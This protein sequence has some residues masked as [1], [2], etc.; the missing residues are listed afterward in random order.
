MSLITEYRTLEEN[1]KELQ[2]RLKNLSQDDKLKK[3][4]EF[5][6]KLRTLMG[7]YQKSLRDIIALLDPDA[8][9]GKAQRNAKAAPTG[10]KR[11][12]KVKQYKNPN[13]GE[14]IETKGGNHKTLKEWKAKWGADVVEGWATLLG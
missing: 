9:A 4:L 12:R 8:K 13:T 1:I 10:S 11:A 3:E 2:E 6:G 7:E 14:V 5:E